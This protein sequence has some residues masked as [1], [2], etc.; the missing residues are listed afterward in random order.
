MTRSL[1]WI[2]PSHWSELLNAAG[3]KAVAPGSFHSPASWTSRPYGAPASASPAPGR[4]VPKPD[5]SSP[6]AFTPAKAPPATPVPQLEHE[7]KREREGIEAA[8]SAPSTSRPIPPVP[9]LEGNLESRLQTFLEWAKSAA[10]AGEAFIADSNGLPVANSGADVDYIAASASVLSSL[11]Q[12]RA[13]LGRPSTGVVSLGLSDTEAYTLTETT[14]D[15][16]R[17]A[18]C[19]IS[20]APPAPEVISRIREELQGIFVMKGA[21]DE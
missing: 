9:E 17:F 21:A 4:T 13:M 5:S 8:G 6:A 14:N 7:G 15:W 2:D 1:L 20:A 16:G 18:L 10:D 19:L 11:T 3:I 12:V